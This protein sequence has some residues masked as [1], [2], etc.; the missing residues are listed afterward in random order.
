MCVCA[1]F[2]CDP[3]Y[4]FLEHIVT[5]QQ[6]LKPN[7][8]NHLT[9]LILFFPRLWKTFH[10][11]SHCTAGTEKKEF[12]RTKRVGLINYKP[13]L[14]YF[15]QQKHYNEMPLKSEALR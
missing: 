11:K 9:Y 6:W 13:K 2:E 3:H 14:L 12:V 10:Y 5:G 4:S 15:F 1:S 7:N 8:V